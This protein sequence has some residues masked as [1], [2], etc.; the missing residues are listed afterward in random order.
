MVLVV[1]EEVGRALLR[2]PT[3]TSAV[4]YIPLRQ[5]S[6]Y[7]FFPPDVDYKELICGANEFSVNISLVLVGDPHCLLLIGMM[8]SGVE[9]AGSFSR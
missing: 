5:T 4:V 1:G 6:A 3:P 9:R 8:G 7:L 2:R